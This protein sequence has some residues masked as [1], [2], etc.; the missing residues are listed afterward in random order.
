MGR[1]NCPCPCASVGLVVD[2]TKVPPASV[3]EAVCCVG[4]V[5]INDPDGKPIG[6]LSVDVE[7]GYLSYIEVWYYDEP[8]SP[9]PPHEQLVVERPTNQ[10][11]RSWLRRWR[12]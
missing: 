1:Y 6:G 4:D 2:K 3:T 10:P 9:I 8:I 5:S 12:K 11:G 7:N